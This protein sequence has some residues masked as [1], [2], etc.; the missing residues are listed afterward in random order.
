MNPLK[1][2]IDQINNQS[3]PEAAKLATAV[4]TNTAGLLDAMLT[5]AEAC[6][7][8][9]ISALFRGSDMQLDRLDKMLAPVRQIVDCGLVLK[10][11]I[12][13]VAVDLMLTSP[14]P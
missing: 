10:G 14:K 7:G 1:G 4:L 2:S 9:G 12:A 6:V 13:G 11:T 3:L 8:N 5:N